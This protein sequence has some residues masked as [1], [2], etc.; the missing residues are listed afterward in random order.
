MARVPFTLRI[1]SEERD[2]LAN[3]S[4]IEGRPVNQ[5]LNEAIK[6]YLQLRGTK[7]RSLENSLA[8]LRSYRE[9]DPGF[10]KAISAFVEAEARFADPV[11]GSWYEEPPVEQGPVQSRIRELLG[12][13]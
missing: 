11:E 1:E 5:L 10:K 13:A 8:R 2:A 4:K 7:E 3:L 6:S 9:K 12:A